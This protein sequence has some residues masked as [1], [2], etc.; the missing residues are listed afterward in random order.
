MV[1]KLAPTVLHC[2]ILGFLPADAIITIG[3]LLI[4]FMNAS[5]RGHHCSIVIRSIAYDIP[6]ILEKGPSFPL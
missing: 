3:M 1:I 6:A 5:P 4:F 2:K